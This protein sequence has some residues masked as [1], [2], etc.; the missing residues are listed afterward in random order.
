MQ[1][2]MPRMSPRDSLRGSPPFPSIGRGGDEQQYP[3]AHPP[4]GAS[5]PSAPFPSFDLRYYYI[6]HCTRVYVAY[7]L[8]CAIAF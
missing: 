2:M 8:K 4:D 6:V 7:V 1:L 5:F 3:G